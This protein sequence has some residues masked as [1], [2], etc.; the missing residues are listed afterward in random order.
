MSP[1]RHR[2]VL[3]FLGLNSDEGPFSGTRQGGSEISR[4]MVNVT[5][6]HAGGLFK[7]EDGAVQVNASSML[8]AASA[9]QFVDTYE[10]MG[11]ALFK[12]DLDKALIACY[13]RGSGK[14]LAV[15]EGFTG[16]LLDRMPEVVDCSA[17]AVSGGWFTLTG[18][19]VTADM[20][21]DE[22]HPSTAASI[23]ISGNVQSGDTEASFAKIIDVNTSQN[24]VKIANYAG[25]SGTHDAVLYP[26]F[27]LAKSTIAYRKEPVIAPPIIVRGRKKII[28]VCPNDRPVVITKDAAFPMGLRAPQAKLGTSLA[29]G[30]H[31]TANRGYRV[32]CALYDASGGRLGPSQSLVGAAWYSQTPTA[33]NK[34]IQVSVGAIAPLSLKF[35][36]L[37]KVSTLDPDDLRQVTITEAALVVP[38]YRAVTWRDTGR[39]VLCA[40]VSTRISH[41][42]AVESGGVGTTFYL[43]TALSAP[44]TDAPITVWEE[45]Y[46]HWALVVQAQGWDAPVLLGKIEKTVAEADDW[47]GFAY[48]ALATHADSVV[49][50]MRRLPSASMPLNGYFSGCCVNGNRFLFAKTDDGETL[51]VS[52]SSVSA[53]YPESGLN[54]KVTRT[55][56]GT[57]RETDEGRLI[58]IGTETHTIQRVVSSTEAHLAT[59]YTGSSPASAHVLGEA[60]YVWPT[61]AEGML[62]EQA[63]ASLGFRPLHEFGDSIVGLA[64]SALSKSLLVAG[65]RLS[66]A[67]NIGDWLDRREQGKPNTLAGRAL[68]RYGARNAACVVGCADALFLV[69]DSVIMISGGL[70][71]LSTDRIQ[72]LHDDDSL[73]HDTV[74]WLDENGNRLS[75]CHKRASDPQWEQLV[76][77]RRFDTWS[78][79]GNDYATC[80]CPFPGGS[81]FG[82]DYGLALV[83]TKDTS[84][85]GGLTENEVGSDL[86]RTFTILQM[87][88]AQTARIDSDPCTL[89]DHPEGAHFVVIYKNGS[90]NP[91]LWTIGTGYIYGPAEWTPNPS[92][93]GAWHGWTLPLSSLSQTPAVGDII[94]LGGRYWRYAFEDFSSFKTV[95][96]RNLQLVMAGGVPAGSG[97]WMWSQ[98]VARDA[99]GTA[100]GP[101]QRTNLSATLLTGWFEIPAANTSAPFVRLALLG[102]ANGAF[103]EVTAAR[104]R[105]EDTDDDVKGPR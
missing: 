56:G 19:T 9:T 1:Q 72:R 40:G 92:P 95:A 12:T 83:N 66:V 18:A 96:P 97:P 64:F 98:S 37:A 8:D 4:S 101:E 46:T 52:V 53:S 15:G 80:G 16:T 33:D 39:Q 30:G 77:D 29:S 44:I 67:G 31:L 21:G 5:R 82:T 41:F 25:T 99:V 76:Y 14:V 42:T 74:C 70:K 55:S 90:T 36:K 73:I 88:D 47:A 104:I 27:F 49:Q 23:L 3:R 51:T 43:D 61:M 6:G 58:L 69:G 38:G 10:E 7:V 65:T 59:T 75:I 20:V 35:R 78:A 13:E 71:D 94:V 24:R 93:P 28:V 100:S 2:E 103:P 85:F 48:G 50:G 102:V 34:T 84:C 81:A 22:V 91:H 105:Y 17:T 87:V 60:D 68:I 79:R 86:A 57:F 45:E 54:R 11:I 89:G 32:M 63:D 26:S 62:D